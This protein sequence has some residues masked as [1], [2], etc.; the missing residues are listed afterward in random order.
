MNVR[1]SRLLALVAVAVYL[2]SA[3]A[4]IVQSDNEKRVP[5]IKIYEGGGL[6][7]IQY[8]VV[9]RPWVDSWRSAFWVPTHPNEEQ[10]VAALQAE[11]TRRGADALMNVSCLNLGRPNTEPAIVCYGMGIRLRSSKG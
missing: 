2:V 11:A 9:S 6:S 10:A 7:T 8:E 5:E 4:S 1:R 3:C